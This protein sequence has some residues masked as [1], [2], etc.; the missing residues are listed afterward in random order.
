MREDVFVGREREI[1]ELHDHLKEALSG[2][3]QICFVT[4]DA[5]SGKTALVRQFVQ[6]AQAANTDLVAAAGSCNAQTGIGDAY[7]PF[8]EVLAMLTGAA[9]ADQS[10][11]KLAPDNANRLRSVLVRSV[12]VLVEVAPELIGVFVP[13]VALIG[14][15]GKAVVEKV[16]WMDRLDE[17]A[18]QKVTSG[19]P[20]AD[21]SRVFELYSAYVQRMTAQTPLILFLDDLQWAD[22][23]SLYLLFHLGRH[24]QTSRILILAA[25]R[26]SDV[27]QGRA[28]ERHP[29]EAVVHELTRYQ[30]DVT[31]DLDAIPESANRRFVD[32]L[33]DAEPNELGPAFREALY[34]QTCG[35]ALFTVE[36]IRTLQERGD[37]VK[38]G[39]GR[40]VEGPTLDWSALPAR[41]EGV[42]AGRIARLSKELKQT[43]SVAS[44]EGEQFTAEV[45]A[46][47]QG[48]S[49]RAAI[50]QLSSALQRRHRLVSARGMVQ[51][52]YVRLSMY[53]FTHHIFHQYVY[54]SLDAAER[55]Y[56]HRDAGEALEGLLQG[57]TDEAAAQLARHFEEAGVPAK[58]ARYRMEAGNR[59]QRMSAHREAAAHLR[60]GLELVADL[61]P[62]QEQAR[63]ELGLQTSLG[64]ALVAVHGFACPEIERTYA[65]ARE[66]SH[67]LGDPPQVIPV[68]YGLCLSYLMRGKLRRAREEGSR[69]LEL[70][71][72][73]GDMGHVVGAHFALGQIFLMQAD[74]ERARSHLERVVDLYDAARDHD[75]ALWQVHDPAVASLLFLSW[76]LWL[77]G[78]AEQATIRL[79]AALTLAA[80]LQHPYTTT[81]AALLASCF[82]QFMREWSECQAQAEWAMELSAQRDF[83]FLRAGCVMHRGS[84]LVHQGQVEEGIAVL[85]EGVADWDATGTQLA[86]PYAWAR[87]AEAYLLAGKRASGLRVIDESFESAEEAWWWPEQYRI[88]GELLLLAPA[89][90]VEAESSLRQ[91][92][93]VARVQESHSLELRAAMSLA[94]LLRQKGQSSEG[95]RL[96]QECYERF[97]EGLD[98]QDLL[99]AKALLDVLVRDT[100]EEHTLKDVND[101][102]TSAPFRARPPRISPN[103]TRPAAPSARVATSEARVTL[104]TV[105]AKSG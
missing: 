101:M 58:A 32:G 59:A 8:R 91:A 51:F 25:Y 89:S 97:T 82:H 73:A 37:L 28:G 15:L 56:L 18:S 12:Q 69:L 90:E 5:G 92:L 78:F 98:T 6:Q 70:A 96:L 60:R 88:R 84:A 41:V 93:E 23:A 83:Q 10:A 64:T 87:L 13:G 29:L 80:E 24:V 2:R 104:D 95:R 81:Q 99:D 65:R 55:R 47:V 94:R 42:V 45:V 66:L 21:Q 71:Q 14:H 77:Q 48:I 62:G 43:L 53:A 35:H 19:E 52:G 44:V 63:L 7:L 40:W 67:S 86:L 3:G 100:A 50:Q 31:V 20:A 54:N 105:R 17:L 49:E 39:K 46:Q 74:L 102:G 16:G 103:A 26:P 1:E 57:R 27:A 75:L 85:E 72:Q 34:G 4:G 9:A 61:P 11:S 76:V 22:G 33:L 68:L 79:E 36:L 38:D 30:G